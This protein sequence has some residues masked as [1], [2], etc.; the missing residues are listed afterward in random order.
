[1]KSSRYYSFS[2]V[3][4]FTDESIISDFCSKCFKYAWILHL[5]DK[6]ED[7]SLMVPHCH[8]ICS[9]KNN[10]SFNSV[11]KLFPSGQT[12][13][14]EPMRDRFKSFEYLTHKNDPDKFQ[15]SDSLV[16]CNDLKYFS[17]L[18]SVE[19]NI[20]RLE[21]FNDLTSG[22]ICERD[23]FLKYG[24]DYIKNRQI[25]HSFA[26]IALSQF[27]D[28]ERGYPSCC[29]LIDYDRFLFDLSVAFERLQISIDDFIY[30]K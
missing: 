20:E 16:H 11:R 25:Y 30:I 24:R 26:R 22:M 8:I 23:M 18:K 1:M 14:I 2:I 28:I 6:K 7:G 29:E 12:V 9:F 13:L 17:A 21:F 4:Y 10:L 27:D 15:Y 5:D 19:K 3:T